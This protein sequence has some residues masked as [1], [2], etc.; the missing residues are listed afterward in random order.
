MCSCYNTSTNS[1]MLCSNRATNNQCPTSPKLSN[2]SIQE[3]QPRGSLESDDVYITEHLLRTFSGV[4]GRPEFFFRSFQAGFSVNIR[5]PPCSV[6]GCTSEGISDFISNN[7]QCNSQ[8]Y[9]YFSHCASEVSCYSFMYFLYLH[10][11][12]VGRTGNGECPADEQTVG[13][14]F[15]DQ[16]REIEASVW[17]NNQVRH[18]CNIA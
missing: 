3:M 10:S 1:S 12:N 6:C 15:P 8:V 4:S 7:S 2:S 14:V 16:E 11:Q 9:G 5:E 13:A 17:Y 18:G